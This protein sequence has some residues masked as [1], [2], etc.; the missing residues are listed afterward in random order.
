LVGV[1]ALFVSDLQYLAIAA[2]IVF[3]HSELCRESTI[4]T[5]DE[6]QVIDKGI[7]MPTFTDPSCHGRLRIKREIGELSHLDHAQVY[8]I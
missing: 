1:Y 3:G 5:A 2:G 7:H 6:R 4:I 8:S